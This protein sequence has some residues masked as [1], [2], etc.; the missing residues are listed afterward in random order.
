MFDLFQKVVLGTLDAQAK[1]M[2]VLEDCVKKS[3][4]D[5]MD[6][7]DF[8]Q[9]MN[10]RIADSRE[11]TEEF[12]ETVKQRITESNPIAG[13]Q[14]LNE[15]KDEIDKLTKRLSELETTGKEEKAE[16]ATASEPEE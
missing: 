3:E 13:K 8:V 9:E 11:K 1:L 4:I 16:E 5:D 15:L 6:R 7:N 2:E 12:V 10:K 14:E